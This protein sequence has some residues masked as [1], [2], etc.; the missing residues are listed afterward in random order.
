MDNLKNQ[1][2][3]LMQG[4]ATSACERANVIAEMKIQTAN[5][6]RAFG[7]ERMAMAKALKSDLA[8]DRMSRSADVLAIRDKTSMM[9]EGFHQDHGR[10]RRSLRQK[11]IQSRKAVMTSVAS[12][13]VAFAKERVGFSKAHRQMAKAQR[14]GGIKGRRDRSHAVAELMKE[15]HA[16]HGKMAHELTQSLV[17]STQAIK[18]QVAG[19]S[20][21]G[22]S[23]VKTGEGVGLPAQMGSSLLA[24]QS[25]EN[26][27]ALMS[28]PDRAP[29]TDA[30]E[31]DQDKTALGE[32]VRHSIGKP[33]KAKKK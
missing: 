16:S 11:L 14:A 29:E 7:R 13:R 21:S 22:A 10:M 33:W 2:A 4:I 31:T 27:P 20:W 23:L 9:C 28:A 8:S 18:A 17:K 3:A 12:L 25:G 32:T 30:K 6:L 1:V 24:A 26:F 5:M 15:F 19:L